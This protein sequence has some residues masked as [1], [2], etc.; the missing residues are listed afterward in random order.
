MEDLILKAKRLFYAYWMR[1]G[2]TYDKAME[3]LIQQ[4]LSE[5]EALQEVIETKI[6]VINILLTWQKEKQR[7]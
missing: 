2:L 6:Q 7:P 4:E 5:A 3:E 1:S